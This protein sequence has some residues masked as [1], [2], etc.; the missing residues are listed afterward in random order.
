MERLDD[1]VHSRVVFFEIPSLRCLPSLTNICF[2][3]SLAPPEVLPISVYG[4]KLL[5][6]S[7]SSSSSSSASGPDAVVAGRPSDPVL[8]DGELPLTYGLG[9]RTNPYDL[10][11]GLQLHLTCGTACGHPRTELTWTAANRTDIQPKKLLAESIIDAA[12]CNGSE[13]TNHMTTTR[14]ELVVHCASPP[15]VGLNRLEC[16]ATG[17]YDVSGL[18]KHVFVLCPGGEKALLLTGGEMIGIAVG[19]C[20]ALGFLISGCILF[21]RRGKETEV[22][23]NGFARGQMV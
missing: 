15:L 1:C 14:S 21:R 7:Q 8:H 20:I 11:S 19:S 16:T 9:T 17:D 3:P 5:P 10:R 12:P 18:T 22:I 23:P 4:S 2:H 13:A 6:S